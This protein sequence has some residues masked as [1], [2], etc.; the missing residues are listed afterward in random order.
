MNEKT[1]A[2]L[3]INDEDMG[4]DLAHECDEFDHHTKDEQEEDR[5]YAAKQLKAAV[6]RHLYV[7][8]DDNEALFNLLRGIVQ[9][10]GF[11]E[12]GCGVIYINGEFATNH[13]KE[14]EIIHIS[15]NTCA[16]EEEIENMAQE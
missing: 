3:D 14:C 6:L 2:D 7:N 5:E 15:Q 8:R 16:D 11:K 10:A 4:F 1:I 13:Y 9:T 12:Q